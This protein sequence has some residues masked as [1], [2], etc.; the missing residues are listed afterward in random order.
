[1]LTDQSTKCRV[2]LVSSHPVQYGAPLFRLYAA[3]PRLDVT[4]AYCSLQ[5]AEPGVDTEF[6]VE[7]AWD[8]PL[9]DGYRW[10]CPPNRSPR[11]GLR[12]F[13]GLFNPGL[14][15]FVRRG[16]FDA[17]V[18]YGHRAASFWIAALAAKFCGV[19]LVFA[20]D[21]HALAPSDGALWKV[22]FKRALLPR[23]YGWADA[24]FGPSAR[25]IGFLRALGLPKDRCFLTH[26]VV[27]NDFFARRAATVNR[28]EVRRQWNV[29]DEAIVALFAGKL[30][31]R[32]R[33]GDLLEA[34]VLVPGLYV[35]F[36]GEGSLRTTLERRAEAPKLAGRARFLGFVNQQGL[37]EVYMASDVL[38]LPSEHE[39][40]GLVVNE[41]FSCG[42]PAIVSDA[43]GAAGDLVRNGETG[44]VVSVGDVAALAERLAL[45]A[46]DPEL[47]R[48]MGEKARARIAEWGPKQN[49]EAF[50]QACRTIVARKQREIG[51][52]WRPRTS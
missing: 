10:V 25:T 2:L 46:R 35:V 24:V 38:V 20:T 48:T 36:A 52:D 7:V 50:A 16:D 30:V 31:P 5:G 44:Y 43:C 15:S 42:V 33:P 22:P 4:V 13:F 19:A 6:G 8:V 11:P 12:G 47:R 39:P 1:M 14:W 45:L 29:P 37:P 41:T 21:A 40:F 3:D 28:R 49:A 27:D 17:V 32:K 26:Y 51:R 18:C 23:I 34:A 9:L